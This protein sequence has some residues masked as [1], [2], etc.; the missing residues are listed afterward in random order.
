LVAGPDI[1]GFDHIFDSE[2]HVGDLTANHKSS[3]PFLVL[4]QT[5]PWRHAT[6]N[7]MLNPANLSQ[8][9]QR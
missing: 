1:C 2:H 4:P 3:S 7:N 5:A 6:I 9:S 8:H